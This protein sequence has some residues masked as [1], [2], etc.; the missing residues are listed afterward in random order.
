MAFALA[1]S[2][3]ME[4]KK[5]NKMNKKSQ[6]KRSNTIIILLTGFVIGYSDQQKMVLLIKTVNDN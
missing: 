6:I 4:L 1:I 3:Q 2:N 5:V